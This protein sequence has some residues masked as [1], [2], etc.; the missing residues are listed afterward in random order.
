[1]R[2]TPEPESIIKEHLPL[3]S[4]EVRTTEGKLLYFV[5]SSILPIREVRQESGFEVV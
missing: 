1:M 3:K 5:L 4:G 2:L